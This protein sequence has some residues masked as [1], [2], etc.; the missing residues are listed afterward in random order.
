MFC[1]GHLY[2]GQSIRA[3]GFL[4]LLGH[5]EW[6]NDIK[7]VIW[8][9]SSLAI[10]GVN[11]ESKLFK[12]PVITAAC[13]HI[14]GH[15]VLGRGRPVPGAVLRPAVLPAAGAAQLGPPGQ[16]GGRAGGLQAGPAGQAAEDPLGSLREAAH[17]TRGQ[18]EKES[19][20]IVGNYSTCTQLKGSRDPSSSLPLARGASSRNLVF[21][22]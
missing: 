14:A 17:F 7:M 3:Y 10:L 22:F 6:V 5:K 9:C 1:K 4:A 21:N 12:C 18:G 13:L 19:C 20:D 15:G 2:K 8:R 11:L 16:E